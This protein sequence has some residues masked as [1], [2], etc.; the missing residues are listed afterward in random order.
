MLFQ[1]SL[2]TVI[3]HF[4]QL[5]P[6]LNTK[7]ALNHHHHPPTHH[8]SHQRYYIF[9]DNEY[10]I[11]SIFF[12]KKANEYFIESIFLPKIILNILMNRY[13]L[14]NCYWIFY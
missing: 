10:F 9:L 13:F 14:E 12:L 8:P 5:G 4:V 7:L 11:E 1:H 6:K 3:I 2:V